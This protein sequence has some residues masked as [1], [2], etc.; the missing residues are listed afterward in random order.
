MSPIRLA[1]LALVQL[2]FLSSAYGQTSEGQP[3]SDARQREIEAL[4]R[5]MANAQRRLDELNRAEVPPAAATAQPAPS[6][7]PST[8]SSVNPEV[9]P[10]T[11]CPDGPCVTAA[12]ASEARRYAFEKGDLLLYARLIDLVGIGAEYMV[13]DRLSLFAD[14]GWLSDR[15]DDNDSPQQRLLPDNALDRDENFFLDGGFKLHLLKG[16][17]FNADVSLGLANA[18]YRVKRDVDGY[19]LFG[20]VGTGLRWQWR[21]LHFGFEFAW[22]PVELRRWVIEDDGDGFLASLDDEERWD[23]RFLGSGVIGFRF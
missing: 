10:A 11:I 6:P 19:S 14:V 13:S 2:A 17:V 8:D 1:A 12:G 15:G 5:D 9:E 21:R 20:R 18:G 23:N 4:E 3:D 22:Y 7:P 16:R